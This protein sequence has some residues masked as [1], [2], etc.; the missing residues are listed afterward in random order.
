MATVPKKILVVDDD[1]GIQ[2]MLALFLRDAYEVGHATTGADAL[3]KLRR[4][5]VDLVVLD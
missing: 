1:A 3:V 2:E 5:A 4:D